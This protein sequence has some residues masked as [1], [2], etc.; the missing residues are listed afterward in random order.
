MGG[1]G[2]GPRGPFKR[3]TEALAKVDIRGHAR[4]PRLGDTACVVRMVAPT[5]RLVA[6]HEVPLTWTACGWGGI[7]PWFLCPSCRR[8]AAVLYFGE[9]L[10]CRRCA[11]L[12]YPST[13]EDATDLALRHVNALRA[14]LGWLKGMVHGIGLCP[15]GMHSRTYQRLLSEYLT[16]SQKALRGL[17]EQLDRII[18]RTW[19]GARF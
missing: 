13:R 14:R 10:T 17:R 9:A 12:V 4:V 16:H 6:I 1:F 5:G 19:P 7:R 2:S 8:R 15:L 11:G 18:E 3:T